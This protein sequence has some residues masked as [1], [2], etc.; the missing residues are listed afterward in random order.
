MLLQ[1]PVPNGTQS[2]PSC[3]TMFVL[4]VPPPRLPAEKLPPRYTSLP[5]IAIALTKKL[6]IVP[7]NA[8][9]GRLDQLLPS[10]FAMLKAI[11][12]PPTFIVKLPP[13]KTSLPRAARVETVPGTPLP[14]A[15]QLL[16]SQ[17]PILL[18]ATPP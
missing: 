2:L 14:S 15:N 10:H 5:L 16:P 8:P 6:P 11:W 12:P 18:T 4:S 13:T 3:L 9:P 1:T 7:K 17:R